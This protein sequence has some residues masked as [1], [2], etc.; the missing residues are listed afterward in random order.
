MFL[1]K[2]DFLDPDPGGDFNTDP[3]RVGSKTLLSMYGTGNLA[4]YI[5]TL[6]EISVPESLT[7]GRPPARAT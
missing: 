3:P 5:G 1:A 4:Q 2:F 7:L 6:I